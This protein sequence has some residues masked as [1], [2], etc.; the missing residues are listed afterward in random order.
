MYEIIFYLRQV[1]LCYSWNELMFFI[2]VAMFS[3]SDR[4]RNNVMSNANK[5]YLQNLW[6]ITWLLHEYMHEVIEVKMPLLGRF[7]GVI[8]TDDT[9][10]KHMIIYIILVV[11]FWRFV[12][13]FKEW[14]IK[15]GIRKTLYWFNC[16]NIWT[17]Q[18]WIVYVIDTASPSF[19]IWGT[20]WNPMTQLSHTGAAKQKRSSLLDC[21]Y[22]ILGGKTI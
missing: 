7:N 8:R 12:Q 19:R 18:T 15:Y 16:F 11:H 21:M 4:Y 6:M 20:L 13:Y 17:I 5:H 3:T 10:Y 9:S 1:L 14:Q 22:I 2:Y